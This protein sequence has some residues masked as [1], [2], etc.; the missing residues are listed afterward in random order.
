MISFPDGPFTKRPHDTRDHAPPM[1]ARLAKFIALA[2]RLLVLFFA[3]SAP[4]ASAASENLIRPG[5]PWLDS[6]QRPINA[7]GGGV[8]FHQGVYYWYGTHKIEGLSEAT[9]ADG[10]VRAYASRDLV[11]W[12]NLGMVLSLDR[13]ETEDLTHGCNFDRPK[14]AFNAATRE[15]VLF[16]KFYPKGL[17]TK[18]GFVG[19]ATSA[20]P[21]GPF[22]Y[23]HKFLGGNSPE[24]TGDFAMFQ[25]DD[26]AL[27]HLA[28]RKP[29]K[30]FVIGKMRPDYLLPEGPYVVAEGI[31]HATEAPAVIKRG[32]LYWMLG[33]A[34]TGWKPNAARSFYAERLQGPWTPLGNPCEGVNPHNDLGPDLTF[35]GQ[36]ASIIPVAGR[37]DAFVAF[38]D[39]NKPEHPCESLYVWLPISF[40]G[41][42][43][44]IAWR[45]AWSPDEFSP[46]PGP[47]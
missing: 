21:A 46:A 1:P 3:A 34:S 26:G 6:A 22:V 20:S 18:V 43:M 36:S 45:D 14:V 28:V 23:R 47:R 13:P 31:T 16:F 37:A 9:D 2:A 27:Y 33:S 40:A 30:A 15:F 41:D 32:G 12:H 29:D 24:G 39:I 42:R 19:V 10:G 17:G 11:Q 35:G 8:I 38:F 44:S 25:D 4:A 5:T 7:H